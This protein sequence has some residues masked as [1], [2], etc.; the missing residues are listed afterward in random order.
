MR[1][2]SEF[3]DLKDPGFISGERLVS[4]TAG[5]VHK[6]KSHVLGPQCPFLNAR[7]MD[8]NSVNSASFTA[9]CTGRAFIALSSLAVLVCL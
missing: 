7:F 5:S 8:I 4:N 2:S 1:D 6:K 3:Y 9:I